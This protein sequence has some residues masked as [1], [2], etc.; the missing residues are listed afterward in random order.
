MTTR[1]ELTSQEIEELALFGE[2]SAAEIVRSLEVGQEVL[3]YS[4]HISHPTSRL[5]QYLQSLRNEGLDI[6]RGEAKYGF[7]MPIPDKKARGRD[8][9]V[10][11]RK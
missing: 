2:S 10:F 11:R 5:E 8:L 9:F 4:T 7:K 6:G 3:I 1:R